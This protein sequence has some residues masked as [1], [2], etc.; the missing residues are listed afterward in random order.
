MLDTASLL[1]PISPDKPAGIDLRRAQMNDHPLDKVKK[2]RFQEDPLTLPA[3]T[4]PRKIN[5][6][7]VQEGCRVVLTRHSKDLEAAAYLTEALVRIDG[8]PG[9]ER[10]LEI[11]KGLVETFWPT[12][13]PGAPSA[14]DP[15][16]MPALRTK[17]ISWLAGND[18]LGAARMIPLGIAADDGRQLGI[19]DLLDS[20]RV[21]RAYTENQTEYAR[22]VEAKLTT[23]ESW[24]AAIG[25]AQPAHLEK[26]A[27]SAESCLA[28]LQ[29]LGAACE[30]QF[31]PDATP[32]LMKLGE[33]LELIAREMR[34]PAG[35]GSA[36]GDTTAADAM[37]GDGSGGA[38]APRAAS[39]PGQIG[40]RDD[41]VR[42]LQAVARYL[43]NSEPH[44]PVSHMLDRC[45]RWLGMS[46]DQ[47]MQ[48]LMKDPAVVDAMREK[49]GIQPPA[50]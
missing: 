43:R 44:S 49:L 39:A 30:V 50:S 5:W 14:D 13:H 32:S 28:K 25:K 33:L 20:H 46:F 24:R 40:S 45:V 27:A 11:V 47:L 35:S 38:T 1:S 17:W 48:D 29:E 22:L 18:L 23:P 26:V 19:G 8:L 6:G 7:A 4:E 36:S 3:G 10:G 9:L 41:A 31:P 12:L 15:E 34:S 16:L 37:T 2:E 42:A 21:Q